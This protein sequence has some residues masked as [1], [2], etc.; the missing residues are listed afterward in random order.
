MARAQAGDHRAYNQLL[1]ELTGYLR[2]RLRRNRRVAQ[3]VDD[4]VQDTLLSLHRVH[5]IYDPARPFA[6]WLVAICRRRMI[7]GLRR[8][9]RAMSHETPLGAE[10]E[11]I[12]DTGAFPAESE[13]IER[14]LREAVA[15]LPRGQRQAITLL[16]L[17]GMSLHEAASH[18][19]MSVTALKVA[20][21]RGIKRLRATLG[22]AS[23]VELEESGL[24][25][26]PMCSRLGPETASNRV[27]EH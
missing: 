15:Q 19:G 14:P 22:A 10:H 20:S 25:H 7:D 23:H 4:I 5:H 3:D 9:S 1:T 27:F 26:R 6:P 13:P 17:R 2:L 12:A 24:D 21:H 18:S 11:S 16:K 8:R